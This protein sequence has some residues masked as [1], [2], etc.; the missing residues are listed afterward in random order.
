M[1][2][3]ICEILWLKRVLLELKIAVEKS[4]KMFCDNQASIS[5]AKIPV[6]HNRTKHVKIEC[7]FIKGKDGGI[8]ELIHIPPSHQTA[9]I[10]TKALPTT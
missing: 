9:D 2:H 1:A 6:H 7:H 3:G 10:L 8:I 4:M 5:I